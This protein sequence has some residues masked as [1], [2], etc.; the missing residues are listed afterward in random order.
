M[1]AAQQEAAHAKADAVAAKLVNAAAKARERRALFEACDVAR[2]AIRRAGFAVSEVVP[3]AI[4]DG[5]LQTRGGHPD[6]DRRNLVAVLVLKSRTVYSKLI[7]MSPNMTFDSIPVPFN[8][9]RSRK[10]MT[11]KQLFHAFL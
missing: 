6:R 2:D 4:P 11:P 5:G 1:I 3:V 10:N 8:F 9:S 7:E